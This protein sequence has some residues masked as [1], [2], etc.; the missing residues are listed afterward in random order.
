VAEHRGVAMPSFAGY[1]VYSS[2]VLLPWLA[3]LSFLFLR[4]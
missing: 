1:I 3:L 2:C 4:T